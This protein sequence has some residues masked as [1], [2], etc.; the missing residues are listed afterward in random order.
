VN[1]A[2]ERLHRQRMISIAVCGRFHYHHY[3]HYLA[4]QGVLQ[5]ITFSHRLSTF[6]DLPQELRSNIFLKEYVLG[7]HLRLVGRFAVTRFLPLYDGAW[8]LLSP[9]FFRP[10]DV[11]LFLLHGNCVRIIQMAKAA[12]KIIVGEAVNAHPVYLQRLLQLETSELG[13]KRRIPEATPAELREID[14]LDYVL[15]P[16]DAV[17]DSYVAMGFDRSRTIVIP[18]GGYLGD[19]SVLAPRDTRDTRDTRG[20]GGPSGPSG[21]TGR[22]RLVCVA[23]LQVRKGLH[24]LLDSLLLADPPGFELTLIGM[25][26]PDYLRL[27]RQKKFQF[28]HIPHMP[29]SEL[30]Q[31]LREFDVFVLPSIED[32]FA[33]AAME[34]LEEGLPVVVSR[35]AGI[36]EVVSKCGGGLIVDPTDHRALLQAIVDC[37]DGNYP[38]LTGKVHSWSDYAQEL[39]ATLSALPDVAAH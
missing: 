16:S 28:T 13:L 17:R 7:L 11:N 15:C 19:A 12:G 5:Q 3:V 20:R 14:M 24:H 34:A 33:V 30:R 9:L 38:P 35:F 31:R 6:S 10:A 23:Q 2:E 26:D 36:S 4:A 32:G 25:A 1:A 27:L 29:N 8:S 18:Y 37:A 21:P 22:R 39:A